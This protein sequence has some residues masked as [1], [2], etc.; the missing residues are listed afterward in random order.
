MSYEAMAG[1]LESFIARHGLGRVHLVGHSMGGKAAM[2]LAL[3]RPDL[4][5]RL[6]VVD[7]AP[8]DYGQGRGFASYLRAMLAVDLARLERRAEVEQAL[9]DAAPEPA[10][11]AFLASNVE[12][13]EGRLAWAPNLE[14]LLAS[15]PDL[16]GW[17]SGLDDRRFDGPT[18]ALRGGRS[19]YVR[20][21]HVPTFRTLFPRVEVETI[22]E[23][24]HWVHAE[25]PEA[26]IRALERFLG[27]G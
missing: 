15:L 1:D 7:V 26:T 24:G 21:A 27:E 11:R 25:K 8:V 4:V 17:P 16:T 3:L 12:V 6:S 22:A 20:D 10:I 13:R 5:D 9:A 23:A 19:D 18:L 14:A 2:T